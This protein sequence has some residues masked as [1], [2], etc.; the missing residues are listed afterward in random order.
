MPIA[1][2]L[3]TVGKWCLGP[4]KVNLEGAGGP[5]SS[6]TPFQHNEI[7]PL[8]FDGPGFTY[9]L[10]Q[11]LC[12]LNY[13]ISLTLRFLIYQKGGVGYAYVA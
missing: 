1:S 13:F 2:C 8:E 6:W 3:G 11:L 12:E 7:T 10:H 4:E 9:K 5:G